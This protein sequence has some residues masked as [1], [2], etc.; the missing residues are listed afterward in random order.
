MAIKHLSIM[1]NLSKNT[2][3]NEI[4]YLVPIL[5]RALSRSLS[6]PTIE[7][8]R[9]QRGKWT[10]IE[11]AVGATDGTSHKI[12]GQIVEQQAEFYS[13]HGELHAIHTQVVVDTAGRIRCIESW[14]LGHKN[15][16]H[17]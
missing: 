13:G 9:Q 12:Y 3:K 1:F 5:E 7:E 16:V 11:S 6:W 15:D 8:W 17:Q 10:K 14:F 4:K 2:I